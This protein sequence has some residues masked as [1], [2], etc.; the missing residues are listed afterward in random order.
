MGISNLTLAKRGSRPLTP[1]SR[2]GVAL[3][4]VCAAFLVELLAPQQSLAVQGSAGCGECSAPTPTCSNQITSGV[5]SDPSCGQCTK[6]KSNPCKKNPG[7]PAQCGQSTPGTY[8]CGGACTIAAVP[9]QPPPPPVESYGFAVPG[10]ATYGFPSV[11]G[12]N[13]TRDILGLAAKGNI[14]LGDYTGLKTSAFE[15]NVVPKLTPGATNKSTQPYVVDP[16]DLD[17]GYGNTLSAACGGKSPCFDGDYT[18]HDTQR[19]PDG[20]LAPGKKTDGSPRKFYESSLPDKTFTALVDEDWTDPT[21]SQAIVNGVLYTN[22][23]IAGYVAA[24]DIAF[25][26]AVVARDDAMQFGSEEAVIMH[27]TR[28]LDGT[29]VSQIILPLTIQ[30]PKLVD[31]KEA[32][33]P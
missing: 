16:T 27:D 9:C 8:K 32:P 13:Q 21:A 7:P 31:W 23:A 26:G 3:L 17:L 33:P 5:W 29:T 1:R 20:T 10:H 25:F 30:R 2:M 19:Q 14:V 24:T 28:L 6:T 22:H 18:Q 12:D 4:G 15:H 11:L